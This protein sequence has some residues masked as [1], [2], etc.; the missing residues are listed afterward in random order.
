VIAA[1]A[2]YLERNDLHLPI[3]MRRPGEFPWAQRTIAVTGRVRGADGEDRNLVVI[4]P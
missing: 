3:A 4:H 2:D 1:G